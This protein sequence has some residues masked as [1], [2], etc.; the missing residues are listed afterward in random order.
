MK[1][2]Q[3]LLVCYYALISLN[4]TAQSTINLNSPS[5]EI[6]YSFRITNGSA[7]Y[8]VGYKGQKLIDNSKIGL[9][10]S[11]GA[12]ENNITA[13]KPVYKDSVE[14]YNLLVG[15]TS[16]VHDRFKEV[17][18]PLMQASAKRRINL[19]VRAFND[20]L[21]FRYEFLPHQAKDSIV[22]TDEN[23]TFNF[24]GN[25]MMRAL[26]LPDY[27]SAHEGPYT[28]L[29]LNSIQQG[30]L[31]DMPALFEFK[32]N[33]YVGVTEAALLDYAGMYLSKQKGV[34]TGKLSPWP[35]QQSVKVK[36]SLPHKSPWRVLLISDRVG[37]L[38]ESN[39]I[40]SLNE[41]CRMQDA[42]W[43]KPGKSSFPWWNG[44]VVADSTFEPGLNFATNKYYI[45]FCS[46]NNIAYHA[47]V[48][49]GA[50]PWY[51]DDGDNFQPGPHT[52]V[53]RPVPGLDMKQICDYGKRMGVGIRVWVHF[54]ALYPKL[55]SAFSVYEKWGLEGLMVDFMNRDDQQ[56]VN[57]QT[58]IL[59]KAAKHHLHVQFHG[60]YKPT[61]LVRTYPNE[62]TREG[63][64][65]YE[66]NKWDKLVTPDHDINIP[67]TRLLAGSTDYHLGGFRAVPDSLFVIKYMR[68]LMMGTRCHMLAMYVV[69]ENALSMVCDY[70][71]AYEGQAGFK[72][73]QDV[74][75]NW[76]ETKVPNAK[77]GEYVVVA[78]R[79]NKDWYIG[80]ITNHT[81]RQLTVPLSFLG[82]SNYE[83]EI[84]SD[85]T[86]V[87][88]DPNHL[89]MKVRTVTKS[90]S[91]TISM[92]GGGGTAI[93][94]KSLD[95]L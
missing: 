43:I 79:H 25:P 71:S 91:I 1:H 19:V 90:D 61:G 45:D 11:D 51:V 39:I 22:I 76:D 49:Y 17:T 54:Y 86:D 57:M 50:R 65:N 87:K 7:V 14:D 32:N 93:Y 75:T 30:A 74:P 6:T 83:A 34:L 58:E 95:G 82:N 73:I 63:T 67:F 69:L 42:S 80:G 84:Y 85:A 41:P 21:A 35:G 2:L 64:M 15:K 55:D 27:T 12:F 29:P 89:V 72:F 77:S 56:M 9:V 38:I 68:P 44:N 28:I 26:F 37:A 31:A 40:T 94:L 48:E 78:R 3:L 18:I 81:A 60:A 24:T 5:G 52:D 53:A 13:L 10:F 36:A 88:K 62:F 46:R 59:Q 16:H 20:G 66:V 92:A 70:P 47:V 23:T 33:V 4:S 8:T